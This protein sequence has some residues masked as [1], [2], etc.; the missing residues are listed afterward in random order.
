MREEKT[1]GNLIKDIRE[2]RGISRKEL[3]RGL[4]SETAL[5]RYECGER[6]PDKFMA[7]ALLERMGEMPYQYEFIDSEQEFQYS[8]LRNKIDKIQN[9]D[10]EK[11]QAYV[12]EYEKK[13]TKKDTLHI[14]YLFMKK[15]EI[16]M[17]KEEYLEAENFFKKSLALTTIYDINIEDFEKKLFTM[18][19]MNSLYGLAESY[20]L[21]KKERQ[22]FSLFKELKQYMEK[23]RWD[24]KK[25]K[26]YYPQ[27]LY[28][29]AQQDMKEYNMGSAYKSLIEAKKLLMESYQKT[30]LRE[31]CELLERLEQII[32]QKISKI[33]GFTTALKILELGNNGMIT[34]EGIQLW[35]NTVKHQL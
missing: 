29:L 17:L 14:Q 32:P 28:R 18:C 30:H 9:K 27:V 25:R 3:C 6:I 11:T 5:M 15:A 2:N 16:S 1:V 12:R 19:E 7:D 33:N 26:R 8:V 10:I 22:D 20:Y 31:I 35:E 13:I 23:S 34:E 4:C 24:Y 21:Q